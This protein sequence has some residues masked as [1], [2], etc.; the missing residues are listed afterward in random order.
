M[1]LSFEMK[2][3]EYNFNNSDN[4]NNISSY[5]NTSSSYNKNNKEYFHQDNLN[6]MKENS[7]KVK[8]F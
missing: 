4:H 8:I 5:N 6:K 1:S 3:R 7:G 2:D